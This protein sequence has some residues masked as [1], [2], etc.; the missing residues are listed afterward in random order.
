[1]H[2]FQFGRGEGA[3]LH[4]MLEGF[5]PHLQ[6]IIAAGDGCC[7]LNWDWM[8]SQGKDAIAKARVQ[9]E[10]AASAAKKQAKTVRVRVLSNLADEI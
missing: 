5:M 6:T 4:G 3:P 8:Q 1:V 10:K 7:T 2:F 9:I